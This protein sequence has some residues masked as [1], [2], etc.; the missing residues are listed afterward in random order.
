MSDSR[1]DDGDGFGWAVPLDEPAVVSES[2]APPPDSSVES[3]T[4]FLLRGYDDTPP[5]IEFRPR[6]RLSGEAA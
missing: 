3:D 2:P 6:L 5:T 1:L 4:S